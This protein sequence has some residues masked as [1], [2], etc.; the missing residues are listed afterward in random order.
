MQRVDG[1]QSVKVSLNDG[2]TIL[3]LRPDNRVTLAKLRQV[4]KDNGFVPKEAQIIVRGAPATNGTTVFDVSGTNE[5]L[6][7]TTPARQMG[8]DWLVTVGAASK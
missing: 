2:L 3:D 6:V 8:D 4:I 5:R 1:V 7:L